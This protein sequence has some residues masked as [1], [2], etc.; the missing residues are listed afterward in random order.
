MTISEIGF[1]TLFFLNDLKI[2]FHKAISKDIKRGAYNFLGW[3]ITFRYYIYLVHI[4]H[5][6]TLRM[7]LQST[8]E[9]FLQK[10]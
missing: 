7:I 5:I 1:L 6:S 8:A 2:S 10:L 9:N 3:S 4:G